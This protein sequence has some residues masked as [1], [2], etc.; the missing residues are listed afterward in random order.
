[1]STTDANQSFPKNV[2]VYICIVIAVLVA[3]STCLNL[4]AVTTITKIL[5]PTSFENPTLN[6]IF[7]TALSD[8]LYTLVP[9]VAS[10]VSLAAG[11]TM[12]KGIFS[13]IICNVTGFTFNVTTRQAILSILGLSVVRLIAITKPIHFKRVIRGSLIKKFIITAWILPILVS[14]APFLKGEQYTYSS[15]ISVCSFSIHQ[16]VPDG[17]LTVWA[18]LFLVIFP[19]MVPGILIIIMYV[20]IVVTMWRIRQRRKAFTM[21]RSALRMESVSQSHT[22]NKA[23]ISTDSGIL[24]IQKDCDKS[25]DSDGKGKWLKHATLTTVV[26]MSLFLLCYISYWS[27]NVEVLIKYINH[28]YLKKQFTPT[29]NFWFLTKLRFEDFCYCTIGSYLMILLN[30]LINPFIFLL[31][32]NRKKNHSKEERTFPTIDD[33]VRTSKSSPKFRV[34]D[35]FPRSPRM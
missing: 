30:A 7:N 29:F 17:K 2:D 33:N 15:Y 4:M 31:S 21:A 23:T 20:S 34:R 1:M 11:R 10:F 22:D 9:M 6:I 12:G 3:A 19:F 28:F 13:D 32:N 27:I 14:I 25:G 35:T 18:H 16:I 24:T 8:L 5:T 26:V